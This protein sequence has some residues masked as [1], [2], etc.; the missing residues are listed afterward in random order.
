[1]GQSESWENLHVTCRE[2]KPEYQNRDATIHPLNN[3]LL[4]KVGKS[5]GRACVVLRLL[6][7]RENPFKHSLYASNGSGDHSARLDVAGFTDGLGNNDCELGSAKQFQGRALRVRRSRRLT[8]ACA[9][10]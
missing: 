8:L 7:F 6:Q 3:R 1:M 5:K 4:K 10:E 9:T 2:T